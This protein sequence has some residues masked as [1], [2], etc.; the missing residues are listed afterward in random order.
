M[1]ELR[2]KRLFLF[3]ALCILVIFWISPPP[4]ELST[5]G[6][7][8]L[9]TLCFAALLWITNAIPLA[10]TSL[11]IIVIF[12]GSGMANPQ[13]VFALWVNPLG[14]FIIGAFLLSGAISK[15]GIGERVVLCLLGGGEIFFPKLLLLIYLSQAITTLL[16]PQPIP[17]CL[18]LIACFYSLIEE[19]MLRREDAAK[20]GFIVFSSAPPISI[21]L[22]TGDSILNP[23]SVALSGSTLTWLSWFKYMV[24]PG[25]VATLF[26]FLIHLKFFAISTTLQ[27]KEKVFRWQDLSREEKIVFWC[28]SM[29][30]I[31]WMT[32]I[33]HGI[34]PAWVALGAAVIL[35]LPLPKPV[36]DVDDLSKHISWA[37]LIFLT[38]AIALGT[39]SQ[40]TGLAE[41]LATTLLPNKAMG[42]DYALGLLVGTITI[43]VH[44]IVSSI[45]ATISVITGPLINLT[46]R[47]GWDPLATALI[48]NA[49]ASLHYFL[50][51]Q[52]GIILLGLGEKGLFRQ[53]EVIRFGVFMTGGIFIVIMVQVLWWKVLGL[54]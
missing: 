20:L 54:I 33:F 50:H 32:D 44:M 47:A 38:G 49:A 46:D 26:T 2:R 12:M 3:I 40:E 24:V 5:A 4:R 53:K 52:N 22:L 29:A 34:A 42:N 27:V 16:I 21:I 41:W 43:V 31:A 36:L 48:V 8:T 13:S 28:L 11:M 39:V 1:D 35:A 6:W 37:L 30:I 19:N 45:L 10:Y 51:F 25:L 15:T 18:M 17:R 14:W 9:G 23:A 7:R